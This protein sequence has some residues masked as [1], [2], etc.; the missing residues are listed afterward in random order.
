MY[1]DE[2]DVELVG[3]SNLDWDGNLDDRRSTSGYAFN[4]RLLVME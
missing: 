4:I 1:T 2:S 3:F